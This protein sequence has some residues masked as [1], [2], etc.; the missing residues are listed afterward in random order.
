MI[1]RD[2]NHPS[3]VAWSIG[4]EL[5]EAWLESDEGVERAKMLQDFAEKCNRSGSTQMHLML[6]SHK[7]ISN[8]I[9]KLP[10]QKVDGWRG[11]SERFQHIHLNNNFRQKGIPSPSH[12]KS[13]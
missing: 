11:V 13:I 4:N 3:I 1:V 2:R 7:E 6:I 5:Q 9:D 10:K 8:Y 12:Q